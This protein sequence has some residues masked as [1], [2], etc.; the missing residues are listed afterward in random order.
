MSENRF[1]PPMA[2]AFPAVVALMRC[3]RFD[4][5]A[6]PGF[7]I[8]GKIDGTMGTLI[9]DL[10]RQNFANLVRSLAVTA[11]LALAI[12]AVRGGVSLAVGPNVNISKSSGNNAEECIAIN[13]RNPLNLFASET[14]S[15]M[16]KYSMDG[17]TTWN[18][19]DVSSLPG[20][21]GDVSA[22]FDTFGNLFLVR[23]GTSIRVM[24][25]LSTNGGASFSL[26]F[27]TSDNNLDQPSVA[28]GPSAVPGQASVWIN[29]TTFSGSQV[30]RGAAVTGIGV[31]GSFSAAQTAGTN[32]DYG[33]IVVGPA[34]KV[35]T[36]YQDAN[37]GIGPDV[38]L[39]NLDADG[40][41]AGGFG[42]QIN[43][44]T[45]QVGSFAPI[46]AQPQRDIDAEAGLA[47]DCSGGPYNGRLYLVY[48]DRSSTL[49]ADTDIYVRFSDDNGATWSSRVRVNDD[50][51]ANGKSQFLP[52]IAIDQTSGN[53]AVSFYDSRNSP[54]N[55]TA[56]LWATVSTDGGATFLP[57]VKVS[58][59]VSS[60]L[61]T[62]ISNTGFDFGDYC[63][64][65]FHGGT[66]YPCWADNSNSTGDNPAGAQNN[67]DI[68]TARVTVNVPLVMLNPR[69]TNPTFRA[70]VQ[71]VAAKTYFLESSPSLNPS[72][73]S[74]VTSVPGDGTVKDL[75]DSNATAPTQFYRIRSQ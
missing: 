72:N 43:T 62:A 50:A 60:A 54:G 35:F 55:N 73:W 33:D 42:P 9:T 6:F 44:T 21:I 74:A 2:S 23:L 16:T 26:L 68:Y 28:T 57:N 17:G 37:G 1:A 15:L 32:G 11:L 30:A 75:V 48:T 8:A 27:Q 34:G 7:G 24:V 36:V 29:Y 70:S 51:I 40:L 58:A 53:I 64:P 14:Y 66:F 18:N 22:A 39:A 20:S 47:W 19:S 12:T 52:R 41:G 4:L 25:G 71:T 56:E 63:G 45:T 5:F 67:F 46:P 38:I 13:P 69:Y 61:V 49:S 59:G 10:P 31:V 3:T 65:C